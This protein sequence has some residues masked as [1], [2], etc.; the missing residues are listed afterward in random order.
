MD[1]PFESR[2]HAG[3]VYAV[4]ARRRPGRGDHH[5]R[6]SRSMT[7]SSA[8][9]RKG[10]WRDVVWQ[11]VRWEVMRYLRNKQFIIGLFIT[12]VIFA[13][14]GALP[15]V[16]Q[17]LDQ[18]RAETYLVVDEIDGSPLLQAALAGSPIHVE[19]V[20]ADASPD[21]AVLAGEADGFF[22]LDRQFVD[23]GVLTLFV[24]KQRQRPEALADALHELL[25][26]LRMQ[27]QSLEVDVLQYVSARPVIIP[28]VLNAPE[29][30][31]PLAG[32]PMSGVLA[33]LMF[34]L[35]MSSGSMLLQSAVQEKRNRMSEVVLSSIGADT[36]MTG[37]IIGHFL[38]GALQI[39][40]WLLIGLPVAWFGQAARGRLHRAVAAAAA[41][42]VYA[43]GV[44]VLCGGVRRRRARPW[45]IYRA[46]PTRKAWSL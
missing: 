23:T 27:E 24:E 9:P 29:D 34:F 26:T 45:R 21:A 15:T 40:F 32:L 1:V 16:I 30:R 37:K 17:R 25:R 13:I 11:V 33:F 35:I 31:P 39:G 19:V 28:S 18:P 42:L 46:L 41:G 10:R 3:P 2:R 43:P 4:A 6:A 36:L 20:T 5:C 7:S 22:V 8:W 12:P 44:Y 38:L 14:F